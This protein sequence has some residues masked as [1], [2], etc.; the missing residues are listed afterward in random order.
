MQPS[1][2]FMRRHDMWG[3]AFGPREGLAGVFGPVGTERR[4]ILQTDFREKPFYVGKS[5]KIV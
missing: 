5:M 2:I 4:T 3:T 1:R